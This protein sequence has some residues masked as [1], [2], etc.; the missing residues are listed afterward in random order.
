M[1][2]CS[3]QSIVQNEPLQEAVLISEV[4]ETVHAQVCI[5]LSF[6]LIQTTDILYSLCNGIKTFTSICKMGG[7]QSGQGLVLEHFSI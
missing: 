6:D 3:A 7:V 1:F 2:N 4:E 5:L